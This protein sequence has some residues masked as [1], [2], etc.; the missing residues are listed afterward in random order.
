MPDFVVIDS[1]FII[2][3]GIG[4]LLSGLVAMFLYQMRRDDKR[5]AERRD[6]AIF[7]RDR[8][9]EWPIKSHLGNMYFSKDVIS[10][11]SQQD[12]AHFESSEMRLM[13][14]DFCPGFW[15][16]WIA[17]KEKRKTAI[18]KRQIKWTR[19]L[20]LKNQII[21]RVKKNHPGIFVDPKFLLD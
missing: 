13:L 1:L 14:D 10:R 9:A 11:D 12:P 3:A 18:D 7:L 5:H 20:H 2:V 8:L 15:K 6:K 4:A 16:E 17:L 21:E 19:L